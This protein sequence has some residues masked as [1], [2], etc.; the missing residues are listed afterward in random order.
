VALHDEFSKYEIKISHYALNE[1]LIIVTFKGIKVLVECNE[2]GYYIDIL[3]C[4]SLIHDE[5]LNII[6]Q[7]MLKVIYEYCIANNVVKDFGS[8]RI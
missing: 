4:S 8:L 3:V 7:D 5:N 1:G 6:N 2:N